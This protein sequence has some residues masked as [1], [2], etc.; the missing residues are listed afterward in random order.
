MIIEVAV[1]VGAVAGIL[2]SSC[3]IPLVKY[4]Y[5]TK[6][7]RDLSIGW[8]LMLTTG[9]GLWATYGVI[10]NDY[11]IIGSNLFPL[12]LNAYLLFVKL[13]NR[14]KLEDLT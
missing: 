10:K 7:T 14:F 1:V 12:A 13:S 8:L 2:T 4:V 9:I 5:T 6:N 11:V 3:A